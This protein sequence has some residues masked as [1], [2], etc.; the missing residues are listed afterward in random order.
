MGAGLFLRLDRW[1][2]S[3]CLPNRKSVLPTFTRLG[4]D[5]RWELIHKREKGDLAARV[6]KGG[7]S[8][9][10]RWTWTPGCEGIGGWWHNPEI[11]SL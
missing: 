1:V 11:T 10:E 5:P 9:E 6:L 2:H 8:A 4:L 7:D 3:S